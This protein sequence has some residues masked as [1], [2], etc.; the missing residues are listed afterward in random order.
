MN[1]NADVVI[2]SFF[3]RDLFPAT[4]F[5]PLK[6]LLSMCFTLKHYFSVGNTL[7]IIIK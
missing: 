7:I 6:F 2:T 1:K 4:K 3:H 5:A